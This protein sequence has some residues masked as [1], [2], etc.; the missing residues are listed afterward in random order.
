MEIND[1]RDFDRP[2]PS[3]W[4]KAGKGKGKTLLP[5]R[6]T[7]NTKEKNP[8]SFVPF[9]SAKARP[10]GRRRMCPFVASLFPAFPSHSLPSS[11]PS[12]KCQ[13]TGA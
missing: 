12:A 2:P 10:L 4:E 6:N 7:K 5:Q 8:F 1:L 9:L 3:P 13:R 11:R